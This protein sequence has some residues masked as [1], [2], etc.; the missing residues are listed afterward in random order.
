MFLLLIGRVI[1]VLLTVA[2][3]RLATTLLDP[4]EYG[5]WILLQTTASLFVLF[6][7]SPF[8]L[9]LNRH[10]IDWQERG[11]LPAGFKGYTGYLILFSLCMT[12]VSCLLVQFGLLRFADLSMW[13]VS[14]LVCLLMIAQT[15]HQ[16]WVPALNFLGD[17]KGFVLGT[18]AGILLTIGMASGLY[19]LGFQGVAPWVLSVAIGFIISTFIFIPSS[20]Y[21]PLGKD[22]MSFFRQLDLR[23]VLAFSGP[24]FLTTAFGWGQTQGYRLVVENKVGLAE[25]GKFAAGY[26]VVAGLFGALEG[27]IS[28]FFQ[29]KY[30]QN[31]NANKNVNHSTEL[32]QIWKVTLYPYAIA[33][34]FLYLVSP[35]ISFIFL[36]KKFTDDVS[37]LSLVAVSEGGRLLLNLLSV[38]YYGQKKTHILIIPQ[39]V[40]VILTVGYM[41]YD[42]SLSFYDI[43]WAL[44]SGYLAA[45]VILFLSDLKTY[46]A[47]S[48]IR[49]ALVALAIG[50]IFILLGTGIAF[51]AQG[52]TLVALTSCLGLVFILPYL[53]QHL[54]G[55]K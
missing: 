50:G 6:G 23:D 18:S 9:Y 13:Q 27:V 45:C 48:L 28:S 36:G 54:R 35:E 17:R 12:G 34:S 37:W 21:R 3:I 30:F 10:V 39:L 2:L 16:T 41:L 46:L 49:S 15:F 8:G 42:K 5:T 32:S 53:K 33:G 24:L 22:T 31:I 7:I 4:A 25:F 55:E 44:G 14:L 51:Y 38:N 47:S 1:Q 11:L 40:G 20:W 19:F 52:L 43:I 26:S 29:A